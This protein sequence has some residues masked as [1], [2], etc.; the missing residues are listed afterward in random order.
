MIVTY[1]KHGRTREDS[2]ALL[3]HLHKPE[4]ESILLLAVGNTSA[5]DAAG[6]LRDMELLRDGSAAVASF[7]HLSVNPAKDVSE[8][9][10]IEAC[11]AVRLEMDPTGQRPFFILAHVKPRAISNADTHAHVVVGHVDRFARSLKDGRI[12][13]RTEATAR[14]LEFR[15]RDVSSPTLGRHHKSAL[16]ILRAKGH[17]DVAAWLVAAHGESPERP[18]SAMSSRSRQRAKRA[19]IN[20]PQA[21]A[22]VVAA[23]AKSKARAPFEIALA[24]LGYAVARGEKPGVWVVVDQQG[25]VLGSVDRLLRLK[26]A[27]VKHLMEDGDGYE[28]SAPQDRAGPAAHDDRAR[29]EAVGE[30]RGDRKAVG[31]ADAASGA[32]GTAASGRGRRSDRD[33]RAVAGDAV[34]TGPSGRY[35][36]SGDRR[37][38]RSVVG[39][40]QHRRALTMLRS[41]AR[42]AVQN[43]ACAR[44]IEESGEYGG[45]R[46]QNWF[47]TDIWGLPIE[48][49]SRFHP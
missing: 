37:Q 13:I 48:P 49:P 23:W 47:A 1:E 16:K 6:A 35:I 9:I 36:P 41:A 3:A 14:L 42:V 8:D 39:Q 7:H 17:H 4:N 21:K 34:G 15:Q 18:R 44:T 26:R 19:G 40:F 27:Q 46:L 20:L 25:D 5:T 2:A 11:H 30:I 38:D 32:P 29:S 45:P 12:K 43:V 22:E 33:H 28:R 10:L 24:A 31:S